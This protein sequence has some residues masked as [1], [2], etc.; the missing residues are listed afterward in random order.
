MSL[1][2]VSSSFDGT[3]I[4]PALLNS[5]SRFPNLNFTKSDNSSIDLSS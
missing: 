4:T 3:G 1:R 2:V 5:I